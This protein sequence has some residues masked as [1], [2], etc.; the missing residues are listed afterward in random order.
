MM[1]TLL[2]VPRGLKATERIEEVAL[3]VHTSNKKTLFY[4]DFLRSRLNFFL[5]G[6]AILEDHS[7]LLGAKFTDRKFRRGDVMKIDQEVAGVAWR[8]W[9][10]VFIAFCALHGALDF[11][12]PLCAST[13]PPCYAG[14]LTSSG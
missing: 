8:F 10:P 14:Y 12:A 1:T 4:L 13:K 3:P 7:Q 11:A 5:V 6:Y 2:M 9:S